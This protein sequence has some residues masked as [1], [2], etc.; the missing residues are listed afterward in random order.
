M[1]YTEPT[2][3]VI[4]AH[5]RAHFYHATMRSIYARYCCRRL[6]VCPSV[7]LSNACIVTKR[8]HL[9]KKSSI[10]TNRK[11]PTGFRL[12]PKLVTLNDLERRNDRV[13]RLSDLY[14]SFTKIPLEVRQPCGPQLSDVAVMRLCRTDIMLHGNPLF[15]TL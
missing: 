5:R 3:R 12:V 8:K 14:R 2:C 11:S 13:R 7:C 1:V 10:M 6:S 9:A 4:A 15:L